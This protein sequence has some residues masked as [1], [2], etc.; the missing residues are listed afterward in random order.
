MPSKGALRGGADRV[1]GRRGARQRPDRGR[2]RGP[3]ER[4]APPAGRAVLARRP[5]QGLDLLHPPQPE[6]PHLLRRVRQARPEGA[7]TLRPE[8]QLHARPLCRACDLHRARVHREEPRLDLRGDGACAR[9]LDQSPPAR[10]LP[11]LRARRDGGPRSQGLGQVV[12]CAPRASHPAPRARPLHSG[13]TPG[14]DAA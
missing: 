12:R 10:T 8:Q 2:H 3:A 13:G 5:R 4:S 7:R 1:D 14:C 11:S 6:E 9:R